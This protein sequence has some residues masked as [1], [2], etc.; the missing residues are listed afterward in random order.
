MSWTLLIHGGAG[1]IL[2]AR[3]SAQLEELTR[4]AL[5]RALDAGGAVLAGGGKA[6]D[7]VEAAIRV[8]EDAPQFNAGRG[9]ALNADGVAELDAAVMEGTGRLAGAVAGVTA[10]RHPIS[11]ARAVMGSAHVFLSGPGADAYSLA[12]GLEQA[13]Q[14][15][16]ITTERRAH[17]EELQDRGSGFDVEMKY[18]TVGAVARDRSGHVA[19]GTSTGGVTGKKWGRIGDSPVIGAGTWADDRGCAVSCTGAG[20]YFLRVG[21]AQA[22]EARVRLLGQSVA[23]ATDAVLA[24]VAALGGI[25]GV[26]VAGADGS[27]TWRFTTPGMNRGILT[28]IGERHI[29]LFGDEA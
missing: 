17:L 16:L 24:E 13:E 23:Q 4:R 22:I 8:L 18:G 9:A 2:R 11:L 15:W 10:T 7:A 29:A 25:G 26:I 14:A 21:V 12:Q 1:H 19:A 20:E 27:T 28:G 3:T 6:L 5:D